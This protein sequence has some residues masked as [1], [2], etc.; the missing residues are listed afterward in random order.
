MLYWGSDPPWEEAVLR[1]R[2]C[3]LQK[4]PNQSKCRFGYGLG[5]GSRKHV[6]DG[7]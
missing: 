2:A 1:G 5:V 4:L 6:L 7:G 3:A